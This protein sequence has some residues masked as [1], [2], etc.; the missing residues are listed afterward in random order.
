MIRRPPR[1]TRTDTL[2]P[3]T[4]LFR[5]LIKRLS[6]QSEQFGK[7][8]RTLLAFDASQDESMERAA[9][10]ILKN[11][12]E[13]GD[14]A[15]LDYTQRFDRN[16]ASSVAALEIERAEWL[17]ALNALPADQRAALET[18][19]DRVRSYHAH[20]R[21]RSWTYTEADGTMLGQKITPP[22]PGG[23]Y[24]GSEARRGG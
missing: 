5:S 17:A 8:L 11:V 6:T 23:R 22:D 13:H 21:A 16:S 12:Q 2:F 1:S 20:Q 14:S 15:V 19:A 18:A 10:D 3:Y 7:S 24:V 9:A 4:T